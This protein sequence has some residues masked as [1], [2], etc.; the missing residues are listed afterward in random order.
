MSYRKNG[1]TLAVRRGLVWAGLGASLVACGGGGGGGGN[2]K[3]DPPPATLQPPV[4]Y[5][6]APEYSGHLVLTNTAPA[7]A[8]GL[9]GAGVIIGVVDSGINRKHPA[10]Q[11]R[12]L[13]NLT[14]ISSSG[15]NLA[16]DDVVGHGTAV[17]QVAAGT[18]FGA[19]PGGIAPGAGLVSARIISDKPP[20]DDG[21]GQGNEVSGALGLKSIHQ[22]L[23]NRGARIMNN[24]WGGLYW[25]NLNATAPIADEY[26]PFIASNGGLVVFATGNEGRA[27]PSSMAALP[28]QPGPNGTLPAAD[29]ERGWL[30]VTAVDP[31]DINSLD[32]GSDGAVYAN[33]CGVAMRYC[34]AAPGTVITTGTNDPYNNPEYWRWKGTSFAAPQV[35]GAAALV[36]QKY[37]Y[38][39][40]DLLR[41]TLLGTAKDIGAAGVDAIFGYGLLDVGAA[42]RGPARFD[43][44]DVVVSFTGTSAWSNPISGAGGLVK[45]GSGRLELTR[46][47]SYLGATRVQGGTL[48]SYFTVPGDAFVNAGGNLELR[49]G[50]AGN[51][52]N[53]GT[54][55][56][57]TTASHVVAGNYHQGS[58]ARFAF[59]VG[60]PLQVTGQ[61][62][63]D[64]GDAQVTGIAQGYTRSARETVLT[65][66]GGVVGSFSTLSAGSGV[67]L[68]ATLGYDPN[69]IWLDI[70]RLDVSVAA[71]SLGFTAASLS[72][73]ERVEGAFS[74]IDGG[75][76]PV[77]TGT[78][79]GLGFLAAAGQI[80]R[81]PT[82]M[83]AERTLESLSGDL[84]GADTAYALMAI[85]G[86]RHALE[87]RLDANVGLSAAG[88]WWDRLGAQRQS[89]NHL[90]IDAQGWVMGH[91]YR[92]RD[93]WSVGGAVAETLGQGFRGDRADR[94][95]NRQVEGQLYAQWQFG[96]SYLLGRISHGMMERQARRDVLLGDAAFGV[97][98]DYDNRYTS[99][100]L[101]LGQRWSTGE[102]GV[103]PYV[104]VQSVR[105]TREGFTEDGAAGFGLSTHASTF[106]A[107]QALAGL[108]FDHQWWAGATELGVT[109][110]L[111]WQRTLSQS[112]NDIDARFTGID[113]WSPI[114]GETLARDIGVLGVGLQA[115]LPRLGMMRLGADVRQENGQSWTQA[116]LGWAVG[117]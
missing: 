86:S 51:L 45:Q 61:A 50:V 113:V 18:A 110:R 30:A 109:G 21:S 70:T 48:A 63:I 1:L 84:H 52:D 71:A 19:W 68:E 49:G 32:K 39:S 92:L 73:A 76:V 81:S 11:G 78:D 91:D 95:R 108:R 6:P 8:A 12:V 34:L 9:T 64:G 42:V 59:E 55:S 115:R 13:A 31:N 40:N 14:Y 58:T 90:G 101:Q 56:T 87:A 104:G 100:G 33:A 38:F 29:L 79:G 22:D 5:A 60:A 117:F 54:V 75:A 46:A 26:R 105:M 24:S 25:T 35:S 89:S 23:I 111:E 93:G 97:A 17:A 102:G 80:Q 82:A 20:A 10:L 41:Q 37:P 67:F 27:N 44:G 16:V 106:D 3:V 15:N 7:H 65:A 77:G 47:N 2:V 36:W 83:A 107:S 69:N 94:E 28:S 62:T 74:A 72:G 57:K 114:L 66:G 4:V 85:E 43:W 53:L 96:R 116:Q 88:G 103:T 98:S 99:M 112:G